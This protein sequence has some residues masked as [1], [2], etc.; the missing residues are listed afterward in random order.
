MGFYFEMKM[1]EE[2]LWQHRQ[3]TFQSDEVE[4][5]SQ[6]NWH[7]VGMHATLYYTDMEDLVSKKNTKLKM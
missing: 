6:V 1:H 5:S 4:R 7:D 3:H 2:L